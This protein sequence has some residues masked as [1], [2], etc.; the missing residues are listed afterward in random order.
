MQLI[1]LSAHFK[2]QRSIVNSDG[3]STSEFS[4]RIIQKYSKN[5]IFRC[6]NFQTFFL[7]NM[8]VFGNNWSQLICKTHAGLCIPFLTETTVAHNISNKFVTISDHFRFTAFIQIYTLKWPTLYKQYKGNW[9]DDITHWMPF[10]L[11]KCLC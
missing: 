3:S 9:C 2:E 4:S 7:E 8:K 5:A 11:I 10:D 6:F 1:W